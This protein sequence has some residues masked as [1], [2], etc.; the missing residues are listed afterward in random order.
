MP[1]EGQRY[2][3]GIHGKQ[4]DQDKEQEKMHLVKKE[5]AAVG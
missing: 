5:A 3:W 1:W 2:S 4:E